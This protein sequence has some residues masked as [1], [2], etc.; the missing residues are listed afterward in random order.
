LIFLSI[1]LVSLQDEISVK[2]KGISTVTISVSI[3]SFAINGS[4]DELVLIAVDKDDSSINNSIIARIFI[5]ENNNPIAIDD[6]VSIQENERVTIQ[7]LANDTDIDG[8]M[9]TV[10]SFD[11]ASSN[12]GVITKA[13]ENLVYTP[14]DSFTGDDSFTYVIQDGRGG[15]SL[16][17]VTV[18][19]SKKTESSGGGSFGFFSIIILCLI[20]LGR[21]ILKIAV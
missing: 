21:K 14:K 7:V 1:T 12:L 10:Q 19:L 2:S 6:E 16:G 5:A 17:T 8:D 11:S 13:G 9:I 3:P 18:H 4:E 20:V 15:S